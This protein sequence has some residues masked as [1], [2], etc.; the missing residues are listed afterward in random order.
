MFKQLNIVSK[1]KPY[2][3]VVMTTS[4]CELLD[5]QSFIVKG[6]SYRKLSRFLPNIIT[7]KSR[8]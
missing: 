1:C 4:N 3:F 7:T 2:L 6:T 8:I 5:N